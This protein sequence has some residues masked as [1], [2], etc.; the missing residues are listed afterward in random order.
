M[1]KVLVF[2][3]WADYAMVKKIFTTMSPL[4]FPFPGRTTLQGIIGAIIG[5][6]KKENPENFIGEGIEIGLRILNPVKKVVI[7]HNNIK[8]TSKKH[9]SR[10][11]EHKPQNIE[12]IKDPKYRIYFST[13]SEGNIYKMLK[14]NLINHHSIYT[15][16][17]GI[18]QT[19][20]NFDFVGEYNAE[21]KSAENEFV[22]LSTV[23]TKDNVKDIDFSSS[24]VFTVVLPNRMKNDREVTEYKEFIYEA[25]G[26]QLLIKTD[27]YYPL[28][29]GEN[30]VFL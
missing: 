26:G 2:D 3:I 17:I 8:V 16:S 5:I 25:E 23:C 7:P 18:S 19:L 15:I 6:D 21:E 12:F 24:K 22:L 30:I 4:S 28:P 20:A 14:N 11:D 9:F 13:A 27:K 29:N 1:I 10:F